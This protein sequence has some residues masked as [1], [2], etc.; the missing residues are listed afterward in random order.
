MRFSTQ[1]P[2]KRGLSKRLVFLI[3]GV[4]F[5]AI[6]L[7]VGML[8]TRPSENLN[9]ELIRGLATN[10]REFEKE[11][12]SSVRARELRVSTCDDMATSNTR[13]C[14]EIIFDEYVSYL[15][16]ILENKT[17]LN[18]HARTQLEEVVQKTDDVKKSIDYVI[19]LTKLEQNGSAFG[20]I[21]KALEES[22]FSL[23]ILMQGV[24]EVF[25]PFIDADDEVL[26]GFGV[27]AVVIYYE[28][29][30]SA[31]L[32][33]DESDENTCIDECAE[34]AE[35]RI[36]AILSRFDELVARF[37]QENLQ[38]PDTINSITKLVISMHETITGMDHPWDE[39]EIKS[40]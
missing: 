13:S 3:A 25:K 5:L 4:L 29:M 24:N 10:W 12:G 7:V 31:L 6:L 38:I 15:S 33:F 28:A 20:I 23:E 1:S 17:N 16:S 14:L 27:E 2:A 11:W 9:Q 39:R 40:E 35:S 32:A 8:L 18:R 26:K 34:H 19:A 36:D 21:E 22:H 37:I 30:E